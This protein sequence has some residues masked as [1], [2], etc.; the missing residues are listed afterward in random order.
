M[1]FFTLTTIIL[2]ACLLDTKV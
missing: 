2:S 1:I